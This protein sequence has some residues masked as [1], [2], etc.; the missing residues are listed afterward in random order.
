MLE[1]LQSLSSCELR[2]FQS[3][4]HLTLCS[5]LTAWIAHGLLDSVVDSFFP[6]LEEIE[7]EVIAIEDLVFEN[8]VPAADS[9]TSSSASNTASS[10][11][12]SD[13]TLNEKDDT[14]SLSE[15]KSGSPP[16]RT[17]RFELPRPPLPMLL[18][19]LRRFGRRSP[20]KPHEHEEASKSPSPTSSTLRRM[21]KA[22]RLVT[23]LTRLLAVKSDIIL[24][25]RKRL[26]LGGAASPEDKREDAA[27][28]AI[29]M[30]DVH[31]EKLC[32]QP[33]ML[34]KLLSQ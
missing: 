33:V 29:H 23:S 9:G 6:F 4:F 30:G 26:L 17:T 7:K 22:R 16:K 24:Q 1:G 28:I 13:R 25:I 11:V 12:Q 19:R 15:K 14:S 10:P 5:R 21:A 34:C 18:R 3:L 20:T 27:E 32:S 2:V 31:G 8:T